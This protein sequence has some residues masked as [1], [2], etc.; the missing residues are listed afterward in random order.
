MKIQ[1]IHS[2][3]EV[4]RFLE[5]GT[6]LFFDLDYTILR[7]VFEFGSDGWESYLAAELKKSGV[8]E[9]VAVQRACELWK[10]VQ[11]V[12]EI[13]W[14]EKETAAVIRK[15]RERKVPIFAIT[16]R[17]FD[18]KPVTEAQ[19]AS[20]GMR[21][22]AEHPYRREGVFADGVFYC[23]DLAKGGVLKEFTALHPCSK[24]VLVDD[25]A[26]HLH[27]AADTLE[28]PFVGLRYGKLD[29][30]RKQYAPDIGTEIFGKILRH[31][32]ALQFLKNGLS[33]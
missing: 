1:E 18:M 22:D 9:R 7:P 12:S 32:L 17:S 21:F 2:M 24:I 25:T 20:L 8:P 28:I 14:V 29:A 16:A 33:S 26:A 15:A 10:A 23:G 6:A 4:L 13:D 5:E 3:S 27:I 31:P 30:H 11:A 19:L